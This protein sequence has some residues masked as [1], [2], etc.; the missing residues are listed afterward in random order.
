MAK[1]V[2]V[3]KERKEEQVRFIRPVCFICEEEAGVVTLKLEMPG[4]AKDQLDIDVDGNELQITGKREDLS[5]EGTYLMR[6]RPFGT[7]RQMY[8]LDD[9][10]DRSKIEAS[11]EGGVLTLKLHRRESE[12][13]RKITIKPS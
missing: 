3:R 4:V 5:A 13:P 10:I 2:E 1:D 11:L 8:T 6:E 7:F 9:T 12:K